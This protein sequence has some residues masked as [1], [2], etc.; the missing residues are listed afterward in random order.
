MLGKLPKLSAVCLHCFVSG[1]MDRLSSLLNVR[2]AAVFRQLAERIR[3]RSDNRAAGLSTDTGIPK[4]G[5][6]F[7][8]FV[9]RTRRHTA[10]GT[11]T[12][13]PNPEKATIH[14]TRLPRSVRLALLAI[15][16][17]PP[18]LGTASGASANGSV[19]SAKLSEPEP[20]RSSATN[21]LLSRPA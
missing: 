20:S 7:L 21:W 8:Y 9:R 6:R 19:A 16:P 5:R 14:A 15:A 11:G 12:P 17:P 13:R 3:S 18:V 2:E 10:C 4:V 1:A